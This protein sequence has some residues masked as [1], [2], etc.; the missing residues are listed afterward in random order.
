MQLPSLCYPA[1]LVG[2]E[3]DGSPPSGYLMSVSAAVE[4]VLSIQAMCP[5]TY[6]IVGNVVGPNTGWL[7]AFLPTYEARAGHPFE[8][9]I[10]GHAY[11]WSVADNCLADFRQYAAFGWPFWITETNVFLAKPGEMRRLLAGARASGAARVACYT[12][13]LPANDP[14]KSRQTEL[15]NADGTLTAMGAEFST[16][17]NGQ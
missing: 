8:G 2:N 17:G 11:C 7:A 4:A 3:P 5:S 9:A 13:R 1:L 12:N 6:L 16:W 10:G 15:L 14:W